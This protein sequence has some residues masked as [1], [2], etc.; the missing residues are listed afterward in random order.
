MTPMDIDSNLHETL[1]WVIQKIAFMCT[2]TN[3]SREK[4][5]NEVP[6][7]MASPTMNPDACRPW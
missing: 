3:S 1:C 6:G 4:D 5:I 7:L 2:M